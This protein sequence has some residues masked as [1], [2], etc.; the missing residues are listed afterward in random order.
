MMFRMQG[1]WW[2]QP[3]ALF[4]WVAVAL[5]VGCKSSNGPPSAYALSGQTG[6]PKVSIQA[7]GYEPIQTAARS[8][9]LNRGYQETRSRHV[10]EQV[11][12]RPAEPGDRSRAI[13]VRLTI[14][15]QSEGVWTLTGEPLL[16]ESWRQDLES[17]RGFPKSN[18]QI[19]DLLVEIK[20]LAESGG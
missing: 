2:I 10:L 14:R 16:V 4:A 18:P 9:F 15:K 19:Y 17:S 3:P 11:F 5:G 20:V 1:Q 12:D 8:F 6:L 7:S 13:R